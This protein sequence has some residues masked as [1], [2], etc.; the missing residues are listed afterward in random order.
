[1]N[2][3]G[4]GLRNRQEECERGEICCGV[5]TESSYSLVRLAACVYELICFPENVCASEWDVKFAHSS[6]QVYLSVYSGAGWGVCEHA[7]V[8]LCVF[9]SVNWTFCV[10]A[11]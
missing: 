6:E 4:R 10:P 7:C 1:M 3:Q 9:G 11:T 2:G 5:I 8:F